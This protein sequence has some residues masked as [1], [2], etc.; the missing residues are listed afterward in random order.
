MRSCYDEESGRYDIYKAFVKTVNNVSLQT[1][2]IVVFKKLIPY[3][4]AKAQESSNYTRAYDGSR[5]QPS[6]NAGRYG[7]GYNDGILDRASELLRKTMDKFGTYVA[8]NWQRLQNAVRGSI[9]NSWRTLANE[10]VNSETMQQFSEVFHENISETVEGTAIDATAEFFGDSLDETTG[11]LLKS[12]GSFEI[13]VTQ[14]GVTRKVRIPLFAALCG[15]LDHMIQKTGFLNAQKL[16]FSGVF[17][18]VM[19]S[20]TPQAA[21]DAIRRYGNAAEAEFMDLFHISEDDI[22]V[23]SDTFASGAEGGSL[24]TG[25]DWHGYA[26]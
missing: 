5:Y 19:P 23:T 18:D 22:R 8:E 17:P 13:E 6:Y 16:D 21:I 3:A 10:L 20:V 12:L 24:D 9:P 26:R 2:K 14:D 1:L 25:T 4:N 7:R 15:F 11:A